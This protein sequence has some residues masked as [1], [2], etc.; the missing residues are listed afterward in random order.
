MMSYGNMYF[1]CL[2][3]NVVISKAKLVSSITVITSL[4]VTSGIR[5]YDDQI[6]IALP[7]GIP[8]YP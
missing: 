8:Y 5:R 4:S 2:L 7:K 3:L 6:E 1:E